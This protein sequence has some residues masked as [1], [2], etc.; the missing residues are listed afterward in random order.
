MAGDV[1]DDINH[2][3]IHLEPTAETPRTLDVEDPVLKIPELEKQ[4]KA[5]K[6]ASPPVDGSEYDDAHA[7][8]EMQRIQ[9]E[10]DH[11]R[12]MAEFGVRAAQ[13]DFYQAF[14]DGDLEL[15]TSIWGKDQPA[16]ATTNMTAPATAAGDSKLSCI[17]P[18]MPSIEG[19]ESI[20][21]SWKEIFQYQADNVSYNGK[22]TVQ[23]GSGAKISICG[24]TAL[25]SCTEEI[26][27]RRMDKKGDGSES[28]T[29]IQKMEALN[30]YKR[31]DGKW[32]MTMHMANP[33]IEI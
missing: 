25:C 9:D 26:T 11:T 7:I 32:R 30:V 8:E 17:H 1:S 19:R 16:A 2:D 21:Q 13:L 3:F 22:F 31:E 27:Y 14:S 33:I 10:L 6:I 29:P 20:L 5:L 4:L 28:S 23:A 18:G 12:S 15:M 24:I